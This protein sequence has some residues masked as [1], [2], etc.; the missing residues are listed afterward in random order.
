MSAPH[1]RAMLRPI[2]RRVLLVL[3]FT[4]VVGSLLAVLGTLALSALSNLRASY[5]A[6]HGAGPS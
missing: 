4:M 2:M 1:A 3:G 6:R 5:R